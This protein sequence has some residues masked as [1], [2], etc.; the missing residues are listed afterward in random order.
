VNQQLAAPVLY[1][2]DTILPSVPPQ[3]LRSYYSTTIPSLIVILDALFASNSSSEGA[4]AVIKSTIGAIESLIVAQDFAAWKSRDE[5]GVQH[6][7]TGYLVANGMDPRPKVRRRVL[8]AIRTVLM[9][10]PANPSGTHPASESSAT[11]CF[12]TV[13]AQFGQG[14]KK[15]GKDGGERDVK[16]VHSLHLLKAVGS[17]VAWPKS[18]IRELVELLLKLSSESYD[19]IVRLA[20]LEV[21]QVIFGQACQEMNAERL[22]EVIQVSSPLDCIDNR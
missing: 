20:A 9:S 22:R 10:P 1:L 17:A 4:A 8:G 15:K 13:Q 21:F 12:H 16:A 6:V 2:L 7:F 18:S 5:K 3:T 19:E 14:K 11:I